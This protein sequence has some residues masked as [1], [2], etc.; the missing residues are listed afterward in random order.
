MP[1]A[2]EFPHQRSVTNS[3]VDLSQIQKFDVLLFAG[4]V[5][6]N[7]FVRRRG[8]EQEESACS[9][10]VEVRYFIC[11]CAGVP[12]FQASFA[13]MS[14]C[15]HYL[16]AVHF[17][18][19]MLIIACPIFANVN[20]LAF[21]Y[22]RRR[23]EAPPPIKEDPDPPY[24]KGHHLQPTK[25]FGENITP[26]CELLCANK[27]LSVNYN[28]SL[29]YVDCKINESKSAVDKGLT[30]LKELQTQLHEVTFACVRTKYLL[31]H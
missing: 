27:T 20:Q 31:D 24:P 4:A 5:L 16:N 22:S 13:W 1:T 7:L 18:A 8:Q 3:F 21:M 10:F 17:G 15:I 26:S 6:S 28:R 29:C 30:K 12:V 19:C 25:S 23:Y 11:L 2:L 9:G 14:T